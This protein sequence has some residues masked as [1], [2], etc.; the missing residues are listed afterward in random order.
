MGLATFQETGHLDVNFLDHVY[1]LDTK[2]KEKIKSVQV[3]QNRR[4]KKICKTPNQLL[5]K[6]K[7]SFQCEKIKF[8]FQFKV[9]Q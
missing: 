6:T 7:F 1:L 3:P 9:K 5:M 4:V 2:C 8:L